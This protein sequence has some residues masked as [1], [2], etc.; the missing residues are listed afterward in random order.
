MRQR[1]RTSKPRTRPSS[2]PDPGG[3][4]ANST[5][6]RRSRGTR[7]RRQHRRR[8]RASAAHSPAH[9][10]AGKAKPTVTTVAKKLVGP[11]SVAQAPDGTRYWADSFAG[12]LYK[13][14]PDGTV[15]VV[16]KSKHHGAE[17]VSADGGAAPL[18]DRLR[19]T[20]SPAASGPSTATERRCMLGDTYAYEKT[21]NPDGKFKYGFL[22]TPKSCL[23]QLPEEVPRL[24]LRRQG[25]PPLRRR[26]APAVSPTSP[27]PAPTRPRPRARASSRTVAA[28]K[29]VKVKVTQEC[30]GGQRPAQAARRQEVR[31][32]G[33]ADRHRGRPRRPALRHQP[34][35]RSRR[36]AAS[37][38][39]GGC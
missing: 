27:T 13:Q 10:S 36:T 28:L 30:G 7:A 18:H 35:G 5:R 3:T 9:A 39:T 14:A 37:A 24:L 29:P 16:Y 25:D 38:S 26:V 6:P 22:K 31:P 20:T 8:R 2:S 19:A 1:G 17:G 15:S 11:L 12:L 33:G 21:A 32:R 4:H 23:A 34:P